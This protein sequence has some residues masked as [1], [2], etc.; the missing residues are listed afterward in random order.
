MC[1]L[2]LFCGVQDLF[3][4]KQKTTCG[5]RCL[6]SLH[7]TM[8]NPSCLHLGQN[9]GQCPDFSHPSVVLG[10][11]RGPPRPGWA[12]QAARLQ[13]RVGR[14]HLTEQR[15]LAVP[16]ADV[17]SG[18][19]RPRSF[20]KVT[21]FSTSPWHLPGHLLSNPFFLQATLAGHYGPAPPPAP[22]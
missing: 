1:V 4:L 3:G 13:E 20:C 2:L 15:E 16:W 7:P 18:L 14:A 11:P 5:F 19:G 9:K 17:T 10:S 8:A 6:T 21:N 22:F 12:A